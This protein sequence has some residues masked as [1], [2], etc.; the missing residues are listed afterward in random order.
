MDSHQ[1]F[2]LPVLLVDDEPKLLRSVATLL[3]SSGIEHVDTLEDGR[4]VYPWLQ[5]HTTGILILDLMMPHISGQEILARVAEDFPELPVIIMTATSHLDTAVQ[6]MQAGACDYLLKPVEKNRLISSVLGAIEIR[7]LRDEVSSLKESLL[8]QSLRNAEAFGDILTQDPTMLSVFRYI[9]AISKSPQPVLIT[10]ETGTGK[11]LIAKAIH[12][13]SGVQGKFIAENI[14][15]LDDNILSD[16]LFGHKKGAFTNADQPRAG[17][18]SEAVNGT[19]FLDEIGDLNES[20]QI[21][22][23]RL[24][25]ERQ[26]YPLGSDQPKASHTRIIV[27]THQNISE[28][29]NTGQFRKD[30]YYRLRSHHIH[31]PPLRERKGDISLLLHHFLEKAATSFNRTAPPIP[32]QLLIL[33]R[34]YPFQGNIRELESMVYDALAC[35][36]GGIL[37]MKTFKETMGQEFAALNQSLMDNPVPEAFVELFPGQPPTLKQAEQLLIELAM[38]RTDGNQ[39]MAA[40]ILGISRQALNQRLLRQKDQNL[41]DF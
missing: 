21:K 24:L 32:P 28:L 20:S 9:E 3:R 1:A 4:K 29:I 35:H 38:E 14:A 17:L 40:S 27:A 36:D 6:C 41:E 16:T 13:A 22:I 33:L 7:S 10:G 19:L 30:L 11:E 5:E 23:L 2:H 39:G 31:I 8:S 15:G 12:Y 37:S 34:N 25:Q 26:Y 18:V